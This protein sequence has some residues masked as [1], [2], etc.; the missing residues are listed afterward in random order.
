MTTVIKTNSANII[1]V[2][3]TQNSVYG[4]GTSI[5][6]NDVNISITPEYQTLL[7]RLKRHFEKLDKMEALIEDNPAIKEAYNQFIIVAKLAEETQK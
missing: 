7:N 2:Y 3:S 4:N 5:P 1:D 6:F